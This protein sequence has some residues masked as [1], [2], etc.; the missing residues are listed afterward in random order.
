MTAL[1]TE[2]TVSEFVGD[3]PARAR[4]FQRLGI[5]FCCGGKLT[6]AEACRKK[7][8]DPAATLEALVTVDRGAAADDPVEHMNLTALCDHIEETHHAGLR[9]ELPRLIAMLRKVTGVHGQQH[10]WLAEMTDV[11]ERFANDLVTHM[12]K[13]ERVLFPLIRG[14]E[15]GDPEAIRAARML[16][17]PISVMEHEH[18]DAGAALVRLRAL[19]HEF[20]PPPAA[21]NTFIAMLDGLREL[22]EDMHWH[23]HKENNLLFPR[24][25]ALAP[26]IARG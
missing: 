13:E 10:P 4:L 7:G 25:L 12:W 16:G 8:L 3:R 20:T 23:V 22:E 1:T 21:C 15:A 18:D 24:A 9:R 6:L 2:T 17:T 14:L 26:D 5:D 19:S 11:F